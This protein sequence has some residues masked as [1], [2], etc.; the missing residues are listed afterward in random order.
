MGHINCSCLTLNWTVCD[1]LAISTADIW[2]LTLIRMWSVGHINCW[3]LPSH[4]DPTVICRPYQLL[5]WPPETEPCG[6]YQP[7]TWPSHTELYVICGPLDI[8][9]SHLIQ[10]YHLF[11]YCSGQT[12]LLCWWCQNTGVWYLKITLILFI[13]LGLV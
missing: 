7:L 13:H 12:T 8:N 11:R 5:A 4:T 1:L 9:H 10:K 6:P 3:H 2:P